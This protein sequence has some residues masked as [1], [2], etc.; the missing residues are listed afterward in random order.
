MRPR[1]PFGP[2]T[3]RWSPE[4][5]EWAKKHLGMREVPPEELNVLIEDEILEVKPLPG[6]SSTI[7]HLDFMPPVEL[8]PPTKGAWGL[9][10][11]PSPVGDFKRFCLPAFKATFPNLSASQVALADVMARG[12]VDYAR[13]MR[14]A[15]D[16]C[17]EV[18]EPEDE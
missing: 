18:V 6:R 13:G 15:L 17:L 7:H 2:R 12:T 16:N 11:R 3:V 10:D 5:V 8:P 1:T 4:M 14:E 9:Y